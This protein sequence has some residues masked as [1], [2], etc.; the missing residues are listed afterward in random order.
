[1]PWPRRPFA[2]RADAARRRRAEA[3]GNPRSGS[4]RPD[5]IGTRLAASSDRD[6]ALPCE[7]PVLICS[8]GW[9]SRST[10]L[11]RMCLADP[12]VLVWGEALDRCGILQSLAAQWRPIDARWPNE[13][14]LLAP[15]DPPPAAD[16]WLANLSPP[17]ASLRLGQ[18]RL[19]DTL[20]G[21]PARAAGRP[22]WGLK[23]VR[24][25]GEEIRWFRMLLPETRIV[26]LVRDPVEAFESY[27][28]RGPWFERWPDRPVT[29]ASA[30]AEMWSRL[31]EDFLELADEP[32]IMLVRDDELESRRDEL[33][34]HLDLELALP[35]ALERIPGGAELHEDRRATAG[36]LRTVRRLTGN[37]RRRLGIQ[38]P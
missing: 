29:T 7:D 28:P 35:S 24:L 16:R 20:F 14:H 37:L 26:L 9:R 25:G 6:E 17:L 36:E 31:V 38:G 8:A 22:R 23:E 13:R 34:A 3:G 15:G 4:S 2:A 10:L 27:A 1:M 11:Q 12:R 5:D 21:A 30:F 18:R 19:L 33:A 32:G